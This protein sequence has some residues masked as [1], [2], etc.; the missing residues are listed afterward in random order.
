M[1]AQIAN[2]EFN[3]IPIPTYAYSPCNC[4]IFAMDDIS[5]YGANKV[6]LATMDYFISK[7]LSFTASIIVNQLA[8]SS[9]LAVF[10]KVEEGVE[11][12]LFEIAIHGYRHVDHSLLTKQEQ[13][14]DFSKANAKL[15]YLFGK[16]SDIFIPPFNKF[17]LHTIEAMVDL[18]ITIFSTHPDAER[19]TINPYKSPTLITTNNSRLEFSKVSD[20]QQPI[21]HVPFLVS[22][23]R[24]EG[25]GVSEDKIVEESMRLIDESIAKYGFAQVRLHPSDFDQVDVITGKPTN[26][27]DYT[28]FQHLTKIVDMLAD[29]NIRIASFRDI[30]PP[31]SPEI[32][33]NN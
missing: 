11:K 15:Q 14:D 7:N 25:E 27:V 16:R 1:Y 2:L 3:P 17:N 18:N 9:H 8:N 26:A 29:R 6:Q 23:L 33:L 20:H 21:Y 30:S 13:E 22:F 28:R 10:H 5:D 32:I 31:H 12:N 19:A 4:V 24:L